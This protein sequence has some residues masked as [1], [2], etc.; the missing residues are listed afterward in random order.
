MHIRP[1]YFDPEFVTPLNIA[2]KDINEHVVDEI[3]DHDF[4]DLNDRRWLVR[5][6]GNTPPEETWERYENLKN[7]IT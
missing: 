2:V 4:S 3:L 7:V 6:I 5:W 1:F